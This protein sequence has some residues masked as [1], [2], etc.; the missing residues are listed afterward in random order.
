MNTMS[1]ESLEIE[2]ILTEAQ[3]K[4]HDLTPS[5]HVSA[6][7]VRTTKGRHVH[8]D[9]A[10]GNVEDRLTLVVLTL[11]EIAFH[12]ALMMEEELPHFPS[13]A[14]SYEAGLRNA[15]S[16]LMTASD[17]VPM[18]ASDADLKDD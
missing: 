3:N 14:D 7:M 6:M 18:I 5:P 11:A 9:M 15:T 13:D 17:M 8:L 10:G 12:V 16:I 2:N 4:V 1:K